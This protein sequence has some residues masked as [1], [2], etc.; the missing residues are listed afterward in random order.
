[1]VLSFDSIFPH[2]HRRHV[3]GL[4]H[5]RAV[6]AIMGGV[7]FWVGSWDIATSGKLLLAAGLDGAS[8]K[9]YGLEYLVGTVACILCGSLHANAGLSPPPIPRA[10]TS[11]IPL[12]LRLIIAAPATIVMWA[13]LYSLLGSTNLG[14]T[15]IT[16]GEDFAGLMFG[17]GIMI[18]TSTFHSTAYTEAAVSLEYTER[19]YARVW[20]IETLRALVSILGQTA[21]WF[22]SWNLLEVQVVE[23]TVIP[24]GTTI[25][26]HGFRG[27]VRR[28]Y[29][30]VSEIGREGRLFQ[31]LAYVGLGY[32]ALAAA[33][34]LVPS[35][36]IVADVYEDAVQRADKSE[37]D[38]SAA[39]RAAH[40]LE[41]RLLLWLRSIVALA[42]QITCNTGFWVLFDEYLF[43]DETDTRNILY[44]LFGALLL[45][46]TGYDTLLAN[47]SLERDT[48]PSEGIA[49]DR[50]RLSIPSHDTDV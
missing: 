7:L 13:G 11:G 30:V 47:V 45:F 49:V 10:W 18:L 22:F 31:H 3:R 40:P 14:F 17:V 35:S 29:E 1:M 12:I 41:S 21:V 5:I 44:V 48:D 34:V 37:G 39:A 38:S 15:Q 50:D 16:L 4:T 25:T 20:L 46:L 43:V 8:P 36:W 6:L 32:G 33:E 19:R 23:L 27:L 28:K 42:G 9:Q 24:A 2:F 26:P